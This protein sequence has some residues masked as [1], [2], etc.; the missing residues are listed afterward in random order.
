LI[1]ILIIAFQ[2]NIVYYTNNQISKYN[3]DNIYNYNV[4]LNSGQS[5]FAHHICLSVV[6]I[7][8]LKATI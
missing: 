6:E 3:N 4:Q 1:E 7:L 8:E 5:C 2:L